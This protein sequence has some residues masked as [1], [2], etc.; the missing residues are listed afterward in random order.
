MGEQLPDVRNSVGLDPRVRDR[1]GLPVPRI[2]WAA[3][4]NDVA[5]IRAISA[6]LVEL[7]QAAGAREIWS[8]TFTPG[9]SAHYLG[10]CRMG[11]DPR[12]SVVDAWCRSHDVPNL[13]IGDGSV[14]VTGGAANPALTIMALAM[15]TAEGIVRAFRHGEL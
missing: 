4:D 14:F 8:P 5:M 6:R 2:A 1:F 15:R 9:W 7:F 11:H 13:Y 3:R 10:S 12:T